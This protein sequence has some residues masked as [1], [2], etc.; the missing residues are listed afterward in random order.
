MENLSTPTRVKVEQNTPKNGT[1]TEAMHDDAYKTPPARRISKQYMT[2]EK[3]AEEAE[4]TTKKELDKLTQL[5]VSTPE[6][7]RKTRHMQRM[8]MERKNR[9]RAL[10]YK[11]F[12]I[13]AILALALIVGTWFA[14]FRTIDHGR[15]PIFYTKNVTLL[16]QLLDANRYDTIVDNYGIDLCSYRLYQMAL[17]HRVN[18]AA[19]QRDDANALWLVYKSG[20]CPTVYSDA[21]MTLLSSY[22]GKNLQRSDINT[23]IRYSF[24]FFTIPPAPIQSDSALSHQQFKSNEPFSLFLRG[25]DSQKTVQITLRGDPSMYTVLVYKTGLG[26]WAEQPTQPW[27]TVHGDTQGYDWAMRIVITWN[28]QEQGQVDIY[29]K[30]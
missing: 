14:Y 28:V 20:L 26:L 9:F 8:I 5:I 30:V 15:D 18:G 2:P 12:S 27:F 23:L 11:Y 7:T 10:A 13:I 21:S 17:Y 22:F 19:F 4:E 16:T 3:F 24:L 6:L 1:T 25:F 29:I